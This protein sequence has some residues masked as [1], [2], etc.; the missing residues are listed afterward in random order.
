MLENAVQLSLPLMP[1][2]IEEL[3]IDQVKFLPDVYLEDNRWRYHFKSNYELHAMDSAYCER[4]RNQEY[5]PEV[6]KKE[7]LDRVALKEKRWKDHYKNQEKIAKMRKSKY[8]IFIFYNGSLEKEWKEAKKETE[9]IMP[10]IGETPEALREDIISNPHL[11]A[12]I[13]ENLLLNLDRILRDKNGKC[14]TLP[15]SL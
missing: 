15:D 6:L 13:K 4:V 7:L 1:S 9:Q 3:F 12:C 14:N 10:Y 5:D 11:H 8:G 2:N